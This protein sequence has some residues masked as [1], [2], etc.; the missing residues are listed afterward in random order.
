MRACGWCL[1]A[2]W[3]WCVCVEGGGVRVRTCV[4][5]CV[6]AR[7]RAGGV[8][9]ARVLCFNVCQFHFALYD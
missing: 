1:C 9:S 6:C 8:V 5:L 2:G 7:A 4:C 3:W